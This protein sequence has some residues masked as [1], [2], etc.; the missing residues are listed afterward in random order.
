MSQSQQNLAQN[1]KIPIQPK[2]KNKFRWSIFA[3][4]P[5]TIAIFICIAKNIEPSFHFDNILDYL[6]VI[7]R[8]KYARLACMA[9]LCLA[10]I[11]IVKLVRN[12]Q[13]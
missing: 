6:D 4:I 3:G 13:D 10:L 12:N 9:V 1:Q 2:T 11:I 7:Q 8:T 5:L